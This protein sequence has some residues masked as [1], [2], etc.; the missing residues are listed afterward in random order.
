MN[1]ITDSDELRARIREAS[2]WS[3]MTHVEGDLDDIINAIIAAGWR[4]VPEGAVVVSRETIEQAIM[5][6]ESM[7]W[8]VGKDQLSAKHQAYLRAALEDSRP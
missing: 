3:D 1:L 4:L 8:Y 6:S 2:E 7:D 5:D